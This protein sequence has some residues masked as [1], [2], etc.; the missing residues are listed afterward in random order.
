MKK[1]LLGK[2]LEMTQVFANDGRVVPVTRVQ[3]GP[4]VVTQVMKEKAGAAVEV[5]FGEEKHASKSRAGHLSGL[6]AARFIRQFHVKELPETV[7]RG[8]MLSVEMFKPG[9]RV[10]VTGISKGKGFQ[11]VVK[12][13]HFAGAP[14]SHGHKDQ[15]RMPGSIGA[16]GPQ[17]VFKGKRMAGRMGGEQV[18]V[19]NLEVISSDPV[20][21]ELVLKG[22]VPGATGSFVVIAGDGALEIVAS[23]ATAEMQAVETPAPEQVTA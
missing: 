20:T 10:M 8:A 22:A 9:D 2:K 7:T 3:A 6:P 5:G 21:H 4:C 18:S 12:R 1:F 16:T 15:S 17:R 11:G 13:H 23:A 19:Q 14:A